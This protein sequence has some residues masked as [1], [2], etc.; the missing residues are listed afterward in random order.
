MEISFV[1]P[2]YNEA[3]NVRAI[4][5]AIHRCFDP[6]N[7]KIECIMINDGSRDG[8]KEALRKLYNEAADPFLTIVNF[9]RNFGKEAAI[10]SGM[11]H[12]KG[13]F[14]CFIDAD[15]Q[16][17]PEVALAMYRKL[18]EDPELDSVA[19]FQDERI[20]GKFISF[21]K[22]MFYSLINRVCDI[23]FV[24]GASDFR[25][26]RRNMID[27][28][29]SLPEY[30][31]FSKGIFSW[32]G[33]QTFYMPYKAEERLSGESSF[34]FWKLLKY[35]GDG[36]IAYST[37][38]LRISTLLG[39]ILAAFSVIYMIIVFIKTLI[40]G[41]DVPGYATT[42][43]LITLIGGIQLLMLGII[44]EYLAKT[45]IQSKNRPVYIEKEVL[46]RKEDDSKEHGERHA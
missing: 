37:A 39:M 5:D 16:Q 19:A 20:E 15:L 10:L 33:Y 40:T 8:T 18:K 32:V 44:G 38:P 12:T 34:S 13:D 1:I 43:I 31:R 2:M 27:S 28:I 21:C 4:Y 26:C 45:Y 11:R 7:I 42:V 9:S 14:V 22:K 36:I 3:G 6:E 41:I 35:A 29:L 46:E 24:S 25:I 23:E 17:N 30:H